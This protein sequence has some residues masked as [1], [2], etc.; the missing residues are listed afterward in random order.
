MKKVRLLKMKDG[1]ESV[2][3]MDYELYSALEK[4]NAIATSFYLLLSDNKL[5]SELQEY[6]SIE[7]EKCHKLLNDS[8]M[9]KHDKRAS[10]K[11]LN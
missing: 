3:E 5:T 2:V 4:L 6:F 10:Y 7:S 9:C 11:L 8:G 1:V